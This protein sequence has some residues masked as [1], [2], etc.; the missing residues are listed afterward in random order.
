MSVKY[1][2]LREGCYLLHLPRGKACVHFIFPAV[3]RF[4]ETV[5]CV[6]LLV[7]CIIFVCLLGFFSLSRET[8]DIFL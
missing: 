3:P 4:S 1:R 6:E 5:G 8:G 2:K 7:N